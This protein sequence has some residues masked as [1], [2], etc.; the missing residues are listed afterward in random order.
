[1]IGDIMDLVVGLIRADTDKGHHKL[2][3]R[4]ME[5]AS[6]A[7]QFCFPLS[8]GCYADG[9]LRAGSWKTCRLH[10]AG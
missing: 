3:G 7:G 1:M 4:A 2:V 6:M 9:E 8:A 10:F 5:C